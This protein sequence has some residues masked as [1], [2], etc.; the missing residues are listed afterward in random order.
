MKANLDKD[1]G[2]GTEFG[3]SEHFTPIPE[4]LPGATE[5]MANCEDAGTS[6]DD[7]SAHP[8]DDCDE[9]GEEAMSGVRLH[10][11]P[12]VEKETLRTSHTLS[13]IIE[14]MTHFHFD[15]H[16]NMAVEGANTSLEGANTSLEGTSGAS[17]N[18]A[19]TDAFE[20][21]AGKDSLLKHST[22]TSASTRTMSSLWSSLAG[23]TL[24]NSIMNEID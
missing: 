11:E 2:T 24:S 19:G 1:A 15:V 22:S 23:S 8:V 10:A 5:E 12:K 13:E 3:T 9:K 16:P 7:T 18:R 6:V 17:G 21:S 14:E 20:P 4:A